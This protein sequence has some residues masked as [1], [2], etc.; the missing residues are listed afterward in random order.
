MPTSSPIVIRNARLHR[1]FPA[2][3]VVVDVSG[4]GFERMSMRR[5]SLLSGQAETQETTVKR[6]SRPRRPRGKR[7]NTIAGTDQK[8]IRQ[9]I[10]GL[11]SPYSRSGPLDSATLKQRTSETPKMYIVFNYIVDS[12]MNLS[13]SNLVPRIP[14]YDENFV[15]GGDWSR[16]CFAFATRT[17][18]EIFHRRLEEDC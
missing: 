10:G 12:S 8:E 5:R 1:R 17:M 15:L 6:R 11:V 7:R 13:F 14:S 4:R 3:I 2:E 9:A 18:E 16:D